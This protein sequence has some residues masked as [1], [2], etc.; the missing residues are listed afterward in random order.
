MT[1]SDSLS[2]DPVSPNTQMARP[3]LVMLD[4]RLETS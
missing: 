1:I 2:T 3:K 4:P